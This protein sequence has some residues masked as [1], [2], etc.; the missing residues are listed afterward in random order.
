MSLS[1]SLPQI[2]VIDTEEKAEGVQKPEVLEDS[3]QIEML[4]I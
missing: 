1:K 2:S 4:F 3:E